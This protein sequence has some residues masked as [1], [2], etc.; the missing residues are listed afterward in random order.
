M[1]LNPILIKSQK[2]NPLPFCYTDLLILFTIANWSKV[3]KYIYSVVDF[4]SLAG[5]SFATVRGNV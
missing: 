3:D 4:R 2:R 5:Y 1:Q